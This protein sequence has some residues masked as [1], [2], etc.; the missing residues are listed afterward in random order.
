MFNGN[1]LAFA[2]GALGLM[3]VFAIVG[4]V[5]GKRTG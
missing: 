2:G 3:L 5:L 4:A 1:V